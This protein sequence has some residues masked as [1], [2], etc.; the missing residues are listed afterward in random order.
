MTSPL[1][2]AACKMSKIFSD[3]PVHSSRLMLLRP[4]LPRSLFGSHRRERMICE[5]LRGRHQFV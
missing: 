4:R 5:P 1:F 3:P 2:A